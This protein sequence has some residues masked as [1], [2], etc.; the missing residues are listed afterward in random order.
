MSRVQPAPEEGRETVP[1]GQCGA[2]IDFWRA[3]VLHIEGRGFQNVCFD[4]KDADLVRYGRMEERARWKL[5][6]GVLVF[7]AAVL[8]LPYLGAEVTAWVLALFYP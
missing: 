7:I 4:C 6:L 5:G 2:L 8:I 1:C 3:R